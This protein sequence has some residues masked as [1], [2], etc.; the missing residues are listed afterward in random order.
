MTHDVE[1]ASGLDFVGELMISMIHSESRV[2][3]RSFPSPDTEPAKMCWQRFAGGDLRSTCMISN[4]MGISSMNKRSF[5]SKQ[6]GST[7]MPRSLAAEVSARE[8]SIV[9]WT[10]MTHSNFHTTCRCPMWVI[11]ILNR[12]AAVQ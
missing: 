10:G 12:A 4:T 8:S 1:T 2:H 7:S 9:G 6:Y 3:F 11:W 5:E